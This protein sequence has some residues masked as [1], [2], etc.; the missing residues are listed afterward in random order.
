MMKEYINNL[1]KKIVITVLSICLLY[2]LYGCGNDNMLE[3]TEDQISN[4]IQKE[5]D[6]INTYNLEIDSISISKRQT[7]IEDKNDYIWCDIDASNDKFSYS[8]KYEITYIL[9]NDGW[10]LET[11]N[12]D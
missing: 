10:D 5:D 9:Y 1:T 3:R 11:F 8:A 4:D 12:K 6:Y 7:N 2:N